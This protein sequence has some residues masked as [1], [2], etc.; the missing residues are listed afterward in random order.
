[1]S[2]EV[3][4]N[5]EVLEMLDSPNEC[6][7]GIFLEA[8]SNLSEI[9]NVL[10]VASESFSKESDIPEMFETL[11]SFN[12]IDH[13]SLPESEPN[14]GIC[15][16]EQELVIE[17]ESCNVEPD[18]TNKRR[19]RIIKKSPKTFTCDTCQA[20]FSKVMEYFQH[21]RTHGAKRFQCK[22]CSRWFSR[23]TVWKRHEAK[24]LSTPER[25]PCNLCGKEF[26]H[27][28]SVVRH[29]I[30]KHQNNR[31]FECTICGVRFAQKTHLQAHQSV[32]SE[33]QYCCTTCDAKFKSYI[34]YKRHQQIHL[35]PSE[36][37]Y[38]STKAKAVKPQNKS[39][40]DIYICP[41][42]GKISSHIN[43]HVLHLR[44]H[45]GER[46]YKCQVCGKAFLANI[47]L[48]NHM[49]I[50]TGEKPHKCETCGRCFRIKAHLTT[51]YLTHTHEK[52]FS[53]Q[54]CSNAFASKRTLKSHMKSH[55]VCQ[56]GE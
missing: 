43:S 40:N 2:P 29:I 52:K 35:P 20:Q 4:Y 10:L 44:R 3:A 48:K 5:P 7:N 33:A 37:N 32:H 11:D 56:E 15:K 50:H 38:T 47:M 14:T 21:I 23:K 12:D 17:E 54:I 41:F 51:H 16:L 26:S 30:E 45:T 36:R 28:Q 19:R 18:V 53:C 6:K 42:C 27:K 39:S 24:H 34:S 31:R 46:P 8:D 13:E 9:A 25:V 22:T 1:M 55:L 49:L